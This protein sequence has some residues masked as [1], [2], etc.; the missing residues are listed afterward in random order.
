MADGDLNGIERRR[1]GSKE[2]PKMQG[3]KEKRK[4]KKTNERPGVLHFTRSSS[5][6]YSSF[7]L[8]DPFPFLF[9]KGRG[10]QV[11]PFPRRGNRV[12][13]SIGGFL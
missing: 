5:N 4:K 9:G 1:T 2:V 10:E 3:S 11:Q 13:A 12:F 8:T 7:L 6:N